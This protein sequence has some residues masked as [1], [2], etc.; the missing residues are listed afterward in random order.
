MFCKWEMME[1]GGPEESEERDIFLGFLSARSLWFG[2]VPL[3]KVTALSRDL[4]HIH[5]HTPLPPFSPLSLGMVTAPQGCW[6]QGAALAWGSFPKL[7][8]HMDF[9]NSP[10]INPLALVVQWL[11]PGAFTAGGLIS[12]PGQGTKIMQAA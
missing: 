2:F 6:P 1:I 4:L 3:A 11:G 10:F 5:P 7:C 8:S 12:V 9:G